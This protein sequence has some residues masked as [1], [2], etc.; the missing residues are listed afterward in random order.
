MSDVSQNDDSVFDILDN[1]VEENEINSGTDASGPVPGSDNSDEPDSSKNKEQETGGSDIDPELIHASEINQNNNKVN[2]VKKANMKY[3]Y[4][5]KPK[6]WNNVAEIFSLPGDYDDEVKN[7]LESIPNINLGDNPESRKWL[8]VL[9]KSMNMTTYNN[10]FKDKLESKNSNFAQDVEF[11]GAKLAPAAP[12]MKSMENQTVKGESAVLRVITH[13]GLGTLFQVPLWHTGMWITF[14]PPTESEIIELNRILMSDKNQLG[15]FSY[16]LAYSNIVGYTVDR[17][18]DFAL[19][20]V[21]DYTVKSSEISADQLKDHI[22]SQDIYALLWG[23]ICSVYPNGFQYQRSCT[24]NPEKCQHVVEEKLNLSKLLWVD[25][26]ILTD[27]QKTH[28]SNRQSGQ[29]DMSSVIRYKEELK[30]LN[31]QRISIGT[32]ETDIYVTITSP[33]IS[34][35]VAA[36]QM[37]IS[38]ITQGVEQVLATDSSPEE[39]EKLIEAKG[40]SSSMRQY[41]QWIDS[42]EFGGNIIEDRE[43]IESTLNVISADDN[44]RTKF[45]EEIYKY[46]NDS[47]IAVVGIPKYNCPVCNTEQ[48]DEKYPLLTEVI[49]I[50]VLQVFFD[51]ITQRLERIGTR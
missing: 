33:T 38:E 3:E 25:N 12:R 4:T 34:Q 10:M 24:T 23:F 11:N 36:A 27:W 31:K 8:N 50:D 41:T 45:L 47:T 40:M 17:L 29:K 30:T 16:G 48:K 2:D 20:H 21:F 49:P 32:D 5:Y 18:V 44:I 19:A 14:K 9:R 22:S 35:Y 43:T 39:K 46:I 42:I 28:M 51:L 13:L 15:R 7:R 1:G 26:S 37:W 6:E